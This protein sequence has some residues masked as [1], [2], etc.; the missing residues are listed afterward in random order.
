MSEPQIASSYLEAL[1]AEH[2]SAERQIKA[3]FG[4]SQMAAQ[5]FKKPT[6]G[7]KL[8]FEFLAK[9]FITPE[10]AHADDIMRQIRAVRAG[11]A[12][13][14]PMA[15]RNGQTL[16]FPVKRSTPVRWGRMPPLPSRQYAPNMATTAARDNR[17]CPNAKA[18]L[19]VIHARCAQKGE[20][21]TTKGTLANIMRRSTRTIQR[22]L[23]DLVTFGYIDAAVQRSGRGLYIGLILKTLAPTKPFYDDMAATAHLIAGQLRAFA[24]ESLGFPD[25]TKLSPKKQF[26][27]GYSGERSVQMVPG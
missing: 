23:K 22:Y 4:A 7:S 14:G 27:Y 13:P 26:T 9:G 18:L 6:Y 21:R 5:G 3:H 2:Q 1:K 19:Q 10:E 17:L 15:G 24:P 12:Q 20:T 8:Y 25:R 16:P 11:W